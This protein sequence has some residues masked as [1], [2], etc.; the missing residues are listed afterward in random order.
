M[1]TDLVSLKKSSTLRTFWP[2]RLSLLLLVVE[3]SVHIE[4]LA[5]LGFFCA[6]E[7]H[8]LG[9]SLSGAASALCRLYSR[10]FVIV[11]ELYKP[12]VAR[13]CLY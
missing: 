9:C 7:S 10:R 6:V 12:N 3:S 1:K 11:E 2:L 4:V 8:M 5:A 13:T